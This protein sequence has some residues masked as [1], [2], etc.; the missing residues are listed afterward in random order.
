[1]TNSII[2]D[3]LLLQYYGKVEINVKRILI[4]ITALL[5]CGALCACSREDKSIEAALED[6]SVQQA[7]NHEP[8]TIKESPDKYTWY[9][10]DYV[11]KNLASIGKGGDERYEGYGEG[12][13]YFSFTSTD[14]S[15]VSKKNLED[16]IVISQSVAPNTELKYQYE[17]NSKGEEYSWI[18]TQNI[19]K[20]EFKVAKINKGDEDA[21]IKAKTVSKKAQD[22]MN[23]TPT[24]I[25]VSTDK[26]TWYLKDYVG[27][28]LDKCGTLRLNGSL[29]DDYGNGNIELVIMTD[30]G[31]DIDFEDEYQ[32][33]SYI[34]TSQGYAPNSEIKFIFTKKSD[35]TEYS[36]LIDY[37]NI[38]ELELYVTK[39]YQ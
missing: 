30:D 1:M 6:K 24:P 29:M 39:I 18:E 36:N 20:I 17:K 7:L 38:E 33:E 2:G 8:V 13:I 16:Y 3:I 26:Y 27:K 34:V 31:K 32:L 23:H 5:M 25:N 11:G 28:T 12:K 9:I 21:S 19:E 4:L 14:G 15:L 37:Q 22:A 10:R 35:G